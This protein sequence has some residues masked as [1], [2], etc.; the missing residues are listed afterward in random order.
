VNEIVTQRTDGKYE[1]RLDEVWL[2]EY[3]EDPGSGLWQ[4]EIFKHNLAEWHGTEYTSLEEARQAAQ[5]FYNQ[6]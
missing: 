6:I 1:E 5:E 3:S 2:A 4:V